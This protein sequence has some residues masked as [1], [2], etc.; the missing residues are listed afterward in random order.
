[1]NIQLKLCSWLTAGLMACTQKKLIYSNEMSSSK[2]DENA[3]HELA[4]LE[5]YS[6]GQFQ[7]ISQNI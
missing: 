7:Q 4:R 3:E 2:I 1:M 5:I 6:L